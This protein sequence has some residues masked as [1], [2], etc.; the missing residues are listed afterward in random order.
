MTKPLDRQ[1]VIDYM[2]NYSV[3]GASMDLLIFLGKLYD[4]VSSG[5]LDASLEDIAKMPLLTG[6]EN[7]NQ[8]SQA[9]R[10]R[11]E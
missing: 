2:Q 4:E 11:Y 6:A 7:L 1:K 5:R 8:Q 9:T 3:S 10:G